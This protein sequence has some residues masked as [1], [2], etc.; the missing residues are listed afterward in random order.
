MPLSKERGPFDG[1]PTAARA[2]EGSQTSPDFEFMGPTSGSGSVEGVA[3]S[4]FQLFFL[5]IKAM[6]SAALLRGEVSFS[7][8]DL[9]TKERIKGAGRGRATSPTSLAAEILKNENL[10][11]L[12]IPVEARP[13]P[14]PMD[15]P[16]IQSLPLA[17]ATCCSNL[18]LRR[19]DALYSLALKDV[20]KS[21]KRDLNLQP[22][23]WQGYALPL[24]YFRQLRREAKRLEGTKEL[25]I[26]SG[27]VEVLP[28]TRTR[29]GLGN[30]ES[31]DRGEAKELDQDKKE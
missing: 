24:S 8:H 22:Q 6:G 11:E 3:A 4:V 20:D 2:E 29:K 27:V 15:K 16:K 21:G 13:C 28:E 1:V 26:I 10:M 17:W 7:L 12:L 23:P 5:K 25:G 30:N 18:F 19:L 14:I 31:Q 9:F